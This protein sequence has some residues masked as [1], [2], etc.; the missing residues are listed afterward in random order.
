VAHGPRNV[1]IPGGILLVLGGIGILCLSEPGFLWFFAAVLLCS[2]IVLFV[3]RLTA[4]ESGLPRRAE[5]N[6]PSWGPNMSK[7]S[8][9]G[10]GGLIFTIGSLAVFFIGLPEIR[11]FLAASLPVGLIVALILR[12]T[13]R[14]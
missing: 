14:D 12:L 4:H 2:L 11:W 13:A 10:A 6:G 1:A 8:F 7:I 9:G 3:L 5:D